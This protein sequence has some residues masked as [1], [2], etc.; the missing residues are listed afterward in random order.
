MKCG[1]AS[2]VELMNGLT[3]FD[4][5]GR[6][7][8]DS[9]EISGMTGKR[10][11]NLVRDI[12]GYVYIMGHSSNLRADDFFIVDTYQAGTGKEYRRY[13][14]TRKGCDMVANKMTGEKGVLFTAAYVAKF[15]EME[16]NL[17]RPSDIER[18]LLNPDTIIKI[19]QNWKEEKEKRER[20]EAQ[21]EADKPKV[22]FAEALEISKDS[23]LI[24][25]LAKILKQ[26]SV[27]IGQNRLFEWLREN[28]YLGKQGGYY[29]LPTQ[30][31]MD[32]GLFEIQKRVVVKPDGTQL[33]TSTPRV[34]GKGQIYFVNKFK[35]EQSLESPKPAVM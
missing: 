9:R 14:L 32:L 4:H 21:I 29:N 33:V 22:V 19:A 7:V 18:F 2:E 24:N 26:N 31:A 6:F 1:Q 25:G 15:E 35:R 12:D 28:G 13:W 3:I 5:N 8:V 27:D 16:S 30:R 23:V 17:S 11:D 34:T 20:L 10:H